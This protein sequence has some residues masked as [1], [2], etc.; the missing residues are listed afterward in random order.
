MP[1]GQGQSRRQPTSGG[2]PNPRIL[3]IGALVL[4]TAVGGYW[5]LGRGDSPS[6]TFLRSEANVAAAARAVP[7]AGAKVQRFLALEEFDRTVYAQIAIITA[8]T[9]R[10]RK[11]TGSAEGAQAAIMRTTADLATRIGT[12]AESYRQAITNT[13][14]IA[15]AEAARLDI[16]V[17]IKKLEQQARAWKRL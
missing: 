6:P 12:S 8:E 15:N 5:F 14:N 1:R 3:V 9:A 16:E 2:G 17:S 4:V 10:L 7:A 11:M 13:L